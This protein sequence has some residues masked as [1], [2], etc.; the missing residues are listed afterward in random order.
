[1]KARP[2]PTKRA[3]QQQADILVYQIDNRLY[4]NLTDRCTLACKFCP[5]HNGTT[6]VHD[7]QLAL[8]SRP[9]P[10]AIIEKIG[11][12]TAYEE[13]V[14]C[15]YG[16][17]TLRLKAL[18]SVANAV[19][20]AGGKTRLNTDGLGNLFHKEDIIP[21]LST[22]IDAVSVSLNAQNEYLYEKHCAPSL[23]HSYPAV[24]AFIER[25]ASW[26]PD[27]TVTAI[28][29]L[30]GIDIPSCARIAAERG[31]KFRSRALDVVG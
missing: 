31:A 8:G 10:E 30:E 18:V 20:A 1:M 9:S 2:N 27:T 17:P 21:L 3:C 16:E 13:I 22:C 7:Y 26:I 5:K 4:I 15:G 14:F 28:E 25:S 12:P 29:G 23:P 24:L 6:K 19:K 11:D